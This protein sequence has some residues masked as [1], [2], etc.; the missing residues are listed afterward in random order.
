MSGTALLD[1]TSVSTKPVKSFK[2]RGISAAIFA[3]RSKSEGHSEPFH[4]VSLQRTY[5]VGDQFKTTTSL[6]RDDL[7]MA[8]FVL[9]QALN[10]ILTEETK[11]KTAKA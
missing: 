7:P 1:D 9:G 2:I 11:Q 10:W 4:K 8:Q 3:N 5:K 6:S